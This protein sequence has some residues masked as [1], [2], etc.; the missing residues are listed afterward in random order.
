MSN[1]KQTDDMVS[2]KRRRHWRSHNWRQMFNRWSATHCFPW[3]HPLK[4]ECTHSSKILILRLILKDVCTSV[5]PK[6]THENVNGA[7]SVL[8]HVREK[9]QISINSGM[10]KLGYVD[11]MQ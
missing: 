9:P 10:E 4:A 7:V 2:L 3:R 8:A 6:S 1:I 5:P 11:K